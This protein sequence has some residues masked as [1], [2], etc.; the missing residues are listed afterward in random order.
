MVS[1]LISDVLGDDSLM[2]SS[3]TRLAFESPSES[4]TIPESDEVEF[5]FGR[6][7]GKL[8]FVSSL[9]SIDIVFDNRRLL[10]DVDITCSG[11][12]VCK[13]RRRIYLLILQDKI[14]R[15]KLPTIR[16]TEHQD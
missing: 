5:N 13:S 11:K 8:V 9:S 2:S 16:F 6:F 12:T 7:I 10:F 4:A 15:I 14:Y 3:L 1:E